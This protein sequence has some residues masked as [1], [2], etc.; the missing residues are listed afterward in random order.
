[1]RLIGLAI[2]LGVALPLAYVTLTAVNHALAGDEIE[3]D[4]EAK[5]AAAGHFLWSTTPYGNAH[6]STWKAPG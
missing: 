4:I 1:V 5:F 2:V 3:Y 6:A